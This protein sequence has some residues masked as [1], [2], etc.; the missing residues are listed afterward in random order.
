MGRNEQIDFWY[1]LRT[2]SRTEKKVSI[3]L[4]RQYIEAYLP[5]QKQLKQWSD[6]KK[7]VEEPLI[8][9][10]LFVKIEEKDY[11]RVL[12]TSGVVGFV[13]F[14]G[15]PARVKEEQIDFLKR[16][17]CTNSDLTL[18]NINLVSGDFVDIN[19][20]P[21]AGLSGELITFKGTRKVA[22]K[23]DEIGYSFLFNVP[24]EYLSKRIEQ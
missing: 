9:S 8:S 11:F 17:T 1:A 10:Y 15:R 12:N 3:E 18:S 7:W 20:G 6:R 23:I 19:S 5:L 24:M 4:K 14:S 16:I 21:L 13:S 22:V 2:R